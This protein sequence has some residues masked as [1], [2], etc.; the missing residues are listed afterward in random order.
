M[1]LDFSLLSNPTYINPPNGL[2]GWLGWFVSLGVIVFLFFKW[3][4]YDKR[5]TRTHRWI[6]VGLTLLVPITSLFIVIR[7]P[8]GEALTPPG[9][10]VDPLGPELVLLSAL[11]WV[12][13]AG[14]LGPTPA[15][16]LGA[17]AGLLSAFWSNHSSFTPL[18]TALIALLLGAAFHQ[19]YR[20][21]IYRALRHPLVSTTL[22]AFFYPML[23]ITN[24]LFITE[25]SLANRLD[26]A[27]TNFWPATIAIAGELIIAGLIAE[28]IAS[29]VPEF[30][31]SRGPLKPSPVESSLQT[32]FLVSLAPLGIV[33]VVA[34][35][36]GAWYFT[37]KAAV[38]MLNDR[39]AGSSKTAAESVP[40]FLESGQNL[41]MQIAQNPVWY[42]GT[43]EGQTLVL[44][45]SLRTV[46]FFRQLYLLDETGTPITG[47]PVDDFYK[48]SPA[49][50]ELVGVELALNGIPIQ[51]YTVPP[52][53]VD[54]AAQVSFLASVFDETKQIQ[55]VLIG[56]A[57]L[58][59]NPLAQPVLDSLH[60]MDNVD[61]E[62]MLLDGDGRILYH[63][64]GINIM[65]T[66]TGQTFD[67]ATF[68]E[69]TAPDGTRVFVYSQPALGHPWTIVESVPANQSQQL[70]LN[71][72]APLLVMII[73]LFVAAGLMLRPALKSVT[74]SLQ[75]LALEANRIAG[76]QLDHP[77]K[78]EGEDEIGQ[79]RGAFEQMRVSLKDRLDE[80]NSLLVVSQ[81]VASSLEIEVAV[82]PVIESA[83]TTEACSARVVLSPEAI[84]ELEASESYQTSYGDGGCSDLYANMDEQI[85]TLARQQD[86]IVLTNLTR[87]RLFSFTEGVPRPE[88]IV[89]FALR[90][91]N[92]YYGTMWLAYDNPH[93]FSDEELRFLTTLASQVAL[94]AANN[95]LYLNAE[96][97]RQRLSAILASTPEPVMVTDHKNHLL[98]A[99]PAASQAL[100]FGTD[101]AEGQSIDKL[102][103]EKEL[104]R[105][106][107]PFAE[108]DLTAEV[109]L[110]DGKVYLAMASSVIAEGQRVGRICVLRD[111]TRFKEL[112]TLKSEFVATVS[113]DLRSP[114]TLMRGYA[115]MLEMVGELNDQQSNYVRKIMGSV[116]DMSG[117]V[118][119]LLDLGRI[120]AGLDLQ[121]EMVPVRE[122]VERV[123]GS[124]QLQATQ[125]NVGLE[126][127]IPSHTV[128]LVE[129]DQALLQQALHNLVDNAVK[130]TESGGNVTVN[131]KVQ[132]D[133]MVFAVKDTGI[134][135]APVDQ[136]RLFEKFYRGAQ[137][138]ARKEQGSGLGLAIVKSIADRHSG[139]VWVESQLGL[140]STF[141]F[142]IP[143]RQSKRER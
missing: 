35:I 46:P 47:Y 138:Q 140:G 90:H 64:K 26:Y 37:G 70:A 80:L 44:E 109:S 136:P 126:I 11:P 74:R 67:E 110:E 56:R 31:G 129:A 40:F 102:I 54:T 97:G 81:G 2:Y 131:A 3:R 122:I 45:Q 1:S 120:E 25:G 65:E 42:T 100:D 14:L 106:L 103:E 124:M 88:A 24:A 101:G 53:G 133:M 43:P 98:L 77:L 41:I 17:F 139:S 6:M 52:Y 8:A 7:L 117:L 142:A 12:L 137:R 10:P 78:V 28:V 135:I 104:I 86:R 76:G 32:R 59:S 118:T 93:K 87:V 73:V 71:I 48:A 89:A 51:S 75:N 123:T 82:K 5:W 108:D 19:R 20:T 13:A 36:V 38:Q 111:V 23:F 21:Q 16:I 69:G 18:E 49:P 121:L 95:R 94:A 60:S 22:L 91:E 66:Y 27:F 9:I 132:D 128:P 33:L 141:Y 125:K 130:F 85:M 50:E 57:D 4:K 62:G 92:L 68:Y 115:T 83:L 34:L 63:T 113:H 79:L 39:M 15:T 99:N 127:D 58:D 29:T 61:G 30:W 84:P 116:E 143:L 107:Q 114:L 96:I 119:N 55:G 134:G 112:D 105:L 72:A